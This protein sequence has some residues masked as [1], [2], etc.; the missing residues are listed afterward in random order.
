[1]DKKYKRKRGVERKRK[2]SKRCG[3]K[4]KKQKRKE[5]KM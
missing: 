1:M 5:M 2:L 3:S 4:K